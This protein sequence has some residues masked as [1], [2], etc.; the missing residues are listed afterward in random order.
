M[1]RPGVFY[2]ALM[3]TALLVA[4]GYEASASDAHNYGDCHWS[5]QGEILEFPGG[6]YK[7]IC[8]RMMGPQGKYDVWCSWRALPNAALRKVPAKRHVLIHA[9]TPGVVG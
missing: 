4:L 7:C 3:L 5:E 6:A 1:T 8:V 9:P 2:F